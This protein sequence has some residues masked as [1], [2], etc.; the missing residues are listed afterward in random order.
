MVWI[1]E[2]NIGAFVRPKIPSRA[3]YSVT[4]SKQISQV[5][6]FSYYNEHVFGYEPN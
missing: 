6:R 2:V 1:E 3:R 4:Y 5:L